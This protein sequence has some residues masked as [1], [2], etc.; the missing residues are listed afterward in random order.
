MGSDNTLTCFRKGARG[1]VSNGGVRDTDEIILQNIP[2]WSAMTSQCMVQGR[3]QYAGRNI[4]VYVGGVL[5][6]P[7]DMIVADGDGVIVVPREVCE[8]VAAIAHEEHERDKKRR[9]EQYR[10]LGWKSDDTVE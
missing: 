3:L 8:K 9:A 1:F 5:V 4:P 10:A 6:H 2:F 7:G